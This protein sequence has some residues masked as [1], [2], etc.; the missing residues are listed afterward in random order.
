M[1]IVQSVFSS[2]SHIWKDHPLSLAMKLRLYKA[3]VCSTFTHACEAWDLTNEIKRLI[4]GLNSRCLMPLLEKT[5]ARQL[6]IQTYEVQETGQAY[7]SCLH[8]WWSWSPIG[9]SHGRLWRIATR[10]IN[11]SGWGQETM[12]H[13]S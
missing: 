10:R 7:I 2:L 9:V 8:T 1:D 6:L 4:N 13:Q 12:E 11:L 5:T 3:S